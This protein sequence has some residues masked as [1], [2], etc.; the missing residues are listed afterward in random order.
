MAEAAK[1]LSAKYDVYFGVGAAERP[2]N[3]DERCETDDVK[4]IPGLWVDIDIQHPVAHKNQSLPPDIA[5]AMDLI[6]DNLPPSILVWSG[7]GIH[8]YWLFREPW[9]FESQDERKQAAD[10]LRS[11]QLVVKQNAA[12]K[13]WKI[14]TTSDLPRVLR[15]PGTTNKKLP[16]NPVMSRVI[17]KADIRYNPIDIEDQLPPVESPAPAAQRTEKFERRPTD[18]PA[19]LMLRNCRF[20][21]H[22]QL[23]A[24]SITYD[25]WLAALTN[26]VRANDGIQAAHQVSAMDPKRY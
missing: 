10:L 12:R 23:N 11:I 25:E 19:E 1:K 3:R 9:E 24:A 8:V 6:P 2:F 17:E 13:G 5:A 20:L 18:G 14:D 16:D 4:A 21:Q 26:I 22:C 7:Y 15:V